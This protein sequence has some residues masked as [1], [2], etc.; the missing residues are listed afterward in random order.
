MQSPYGTH[1]EDRLVVDTD[2]APGGVIARFADGDEELIHANQYVLAMLECTSADELLEYTQG[3]FRNLVHEHDLEAA[4]DSIFGQVG[5][6]SGYDH[7]Y[8]RMRTRTGRSITVSEYGKLVIDSRFGRPVLHALIAQVTPEATMDWLTGLPSM[9]RFHH[10]ARMGAEAMFFRGE[11]PVVLA[12][13]IMG[14]KSF[15]ARHGRDTG[16]RLLRAFANV[17][18]THFGSEASSRFAEDHFYAYSTEQGIEQRV[19][20]VF[21]DYAALDF[22]HVPPI[23]AGAY[24]CDPADDIVTAGFDHAKAACDLDRKTW[25]SHITWFTDEMR[26]AAHLRLHVL[27]SLDQAIEQGWI[28][29]HYQAVVRSS[30]GDICNEEALAR[31]I[32][33]TYGPLMP[34]Q[35]IPDLEEAGE[36]YKL[37]LHIVDCVIADMRAKQQHGVPIVPVSINFSLRDLVQLDLADEIARRADD[38]GLPHSLIRI[39]LTESVASSDPAF[40]RSQ[41]DAMH[42]A[43][44]EVWM[45]D[46]GS[47]YSSL[48]TLQEFDFDLIKLDMGFLRSAQ[49]ERSHVILAGVVQAAAKLGVGT[50]TEGVETREQAEFL[51]GI[52]CDMLQGYFYAKPDDIQTVISH[53]EGK[54]AMGR[55]SF[56]EARYWNEVSLVSFTDLEGREEAN[57][58]WV[59]LSEFPIAV[60]EER[61]GAWRILRAND[62]YIEFLES[63]DILTQ[64]YSNLETMPLPAG[65]LDLEFYVA[66]DRSR[67]SRAWERTFGRM[68]YGSGYQ[69]YV[70]Y[71]ASTR[72]TNAFMVSAAPT[73]LGSG[74]GIYGD[75]PVGYAVFRVVLNDAGNEVVDAEYVYANNLYCDWGGFQLEEIIGKSFLDVAHDASRMWF[76][77]ATRRLCWAR[78]CTTSCSVPR[79][80]TG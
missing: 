3:S 79:R 68:D 13:D 24:V 61:G 21:A 12:L 38:A 53:H 28:R 43:G 33:P 44:F 76:P 7:V 9:T 36:L 72:D 57:S 48:N 55:E 47:G 15:N 16:D 2:D 56:E 73:M 71:L 65:T 23:R 59:P 78:A 74:L 64:P 27:E 4:E 58:D 10:L 22:P 32:D 66:A 25:Q 14:M 40:L 45:D 5:T 50:L 62:S 77:T 63:L 75:V 60:L 35:F 6:H 67:H 17:L 80:A 1:F 11:R 54:D 41:I 52:G 29:P 18:R 39:E 19:Q 69:F 49:V 26:T 51:A 20:A 46:F 31:W 70:R 30:T 8:Y 34:D 42:E 37:D